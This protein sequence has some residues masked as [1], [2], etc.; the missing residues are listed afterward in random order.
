[1]SVVVAAGVDD[2]FAFV[3]AGLRSRCI[4]TVGLLLRSCKFAS[5][6]RK[7]KLSRIPLPA[8]CCLDVAMVVGE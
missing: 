2:D 8:A 4:R 3:G 6:G 5:G 7:K 1:M